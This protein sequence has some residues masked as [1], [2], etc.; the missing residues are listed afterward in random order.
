MKKI[1]MLLA[2]LSV[3][4]SAANVQALESDDVLVMRNAS[5]SE[6]AFA[7][8]RNF[9]FPIFLDSSVLEDDR[10][11]SANVPPG[12]PVDEF[13]VEMLSMAGYDLCPGQV[14]YVVKAESYGQPVKVSSDSIGGRFARSVKIGDSPASEYRRFPSSCSVG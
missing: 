1:P 5:L 13:F 3:G 9:G 2:L 14:R 11:F 12:L 10:S 6:F 7:M 4:F 8:S